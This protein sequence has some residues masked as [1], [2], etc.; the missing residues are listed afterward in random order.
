MKLITVLKLI[1]ISVVI[2][3]LF[4]IP[5]RAAENKSVMETKTMPR[6]GIFST[7]GQ[8][9]LT[10][11]NMI[12][13]FNGLITMIPVLGWILGPF[14]FIFFF[15]CLGWWL[16][17]VAY[18]LIFIDLFLPNLPHLILMIFH[19]IMRI[20]HYVVGSFHVILKIPGMLIKD[21]GV[22]FKGLSDLPGIFLQL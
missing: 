13:T 1:S 19:F 4:L 17:I 16:Y 3:I 21:V 18:G 15:I 20:P 7:T 8:V 6:E 2:M 14:L 5:A 10:V 12:T 9:I 22:F 11:L